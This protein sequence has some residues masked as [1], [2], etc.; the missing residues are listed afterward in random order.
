LAALGDHHTADQ[1][2]SYLYR[3]Q[4]RALGD[5]DQR[6]RALIQHARWQGQ[7]YIHAIDEEPG[8]RLMQMWEFN[9]LA[10]NTILEHEGD[11]S[12]ALL[13]PLHGMLQAQYLISDY[14]MQSGSGASAS[15][16]FNDQHQRRLAG[17][18]KDNYEQGRALL[19]AIYNLEQI[20]QEPGSDASARALI[21]LGDWL[22]WHRKQEEAFTVYR[23]AI[24]ELVTDGS[25]QL[26]AARLLEAPAALPALTTGDNGLNPL[27][28]ESRGD[29]L[30]EFTVSAEGQVSDLSRLDDNAGADGFANRLMRQ[31]RRTLFRPR[32]DLAT[33]EPLPTEK[34]TQAYDSK[35]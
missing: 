15:Q 21:M 16:G 1:R 19:K 4:M 7:A 14:Q 2:Q 25:A 8:Q 23:Q 29:I 10:L 9:R 22:L 12:P 18:R 33:G 31:L 13:E 3:V 6:T 11:Q 26:P 24:G 17:Y 20:N 27:A 32:F 30:L 28:S 34:L 35:S 5:P